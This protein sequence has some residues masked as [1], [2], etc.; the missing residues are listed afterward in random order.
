MASATQTRDH[1][2]IRRWAEERGGIPTIVDGTR[3]LLRID[4][5]KGTKSG[6][7]NL[8]LDEVSWD[9]WFRIFDD[10]DLV[11]LH[12]PEGESKFFKLVSPET[13]RENEQGTRGRR[14]R[15]SRAGRRGGQARGRRA[16]AAVKQ[17]RSTGSRRRRQAALKSEAVRNGGAGGALRDGAASAPDGA[18]RPARRG[19]AR[20]ARGAGARRGAAA[21]SHAGTSRRG[22]AA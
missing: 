12:Q 7:R 1:D 16:N 6:G 10:N 8:R 20:A 21:A 2:E 15:S 11:F 5:V 22:A 17:R 18:K 3:G 19:A 14:G 13:A 4:F 9:D